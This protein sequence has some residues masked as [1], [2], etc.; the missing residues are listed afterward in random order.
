MGEKCKIILQL[1][2]R[3]RLLLSTIT[4]LGLG[5]KEDVLMLLPKEGFDE[6]RKVGEE[7]LA[8]G[9]FTDFYQKLKC[10]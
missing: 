6:F 4:E 3:N 9:G 1:S 8:K 5:L 7:I 10:L 2:R